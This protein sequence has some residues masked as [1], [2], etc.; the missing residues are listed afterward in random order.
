MGTSVDSPSSA[1]P[2]S[3]VTAIRQYLIE[4]MTLADLV[5]SEATY[6]QYET[7]RQVFHDLYGTLAFHR[8]MQKSLGER[9]PGL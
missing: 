6:D 5:F 2:G 7:L 9:L 1:T 4:L 8:E 3:E